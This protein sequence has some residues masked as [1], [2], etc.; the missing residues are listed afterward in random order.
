MAAISP[1]KLYGGEFAGNEKTKV[2]TVTPG[3]ASDTV[4]LASHFDTIHAVAATIT[5]GMDAALLGV[6]ATFSGTTV[7]VA[8][9]DQ[10]GSA[11]TDWTGAQVTLVVFGTDEGI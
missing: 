1:T 8:T 4:A 6:Q 2:F 5:G 9:F 10:A 3:S 11:A 7:T